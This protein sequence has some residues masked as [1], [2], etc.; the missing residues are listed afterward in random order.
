MEVNWSVEDEQERKSNHSKKS[1]RKEAEINCSESVLDALEAYPTATFFGVLAAKDYPHNTHAA[2]IRQVKKPNKPDDWQI[3]DTRFKTAI[4]V[5]ET[6]KRFRAWCRK[7]K[8]VQL[9]ILEKD[10]KV[11]KEKKGRPAVAAASNGAV[12]NYAQRWLHLMQYN[13][14]S[15]EILEA[16]SKSKAVK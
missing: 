15:G 11:V 14:E 5:N 8:E 6:P 7:F 3:I 9:F 4:F 10:T 13:K 2:T 16:D 1:S 12:D